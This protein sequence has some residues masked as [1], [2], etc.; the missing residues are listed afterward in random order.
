MPEE[1][2]F[3]S[4]LRNLSTKIQHIEE[5]YIE[6]RRFNY[7]WLINYCSLFRYRRD[8]RQVPGLMRTP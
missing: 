6:I 8:D 2:L 3:F 4:Y 7:D 5:A 1:K